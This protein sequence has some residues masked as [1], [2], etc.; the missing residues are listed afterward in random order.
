MMVPSPEHIHS[1]SLPP[2]ATALIAIGTFV[3]GG[4]AIGATMYA[5]M[6]ELWCFNHGQEGDSLL[7][8]NVAQRSS[9]YDHE[10]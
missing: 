2:Y 6:K 10:G 8:G 7:R 3:L 1:F 5:K 9:V 4:A